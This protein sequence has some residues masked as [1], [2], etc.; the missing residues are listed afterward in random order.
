MSDETANRL[1]T[2]SQLTLDTVR[3]F[4]A[5]HKIDYCWSCALF[6]YCIRRKFC[7]VLSNG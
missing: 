7:S 5:T 2:G 6:S 4:Q 1:R 3:F